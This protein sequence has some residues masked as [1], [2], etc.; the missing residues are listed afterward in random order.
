MRKL[1]F[2]P[3]VSGSKMNIVC[4]VSGSGTNYR[5]IVAGNP[6]RSYLVFTNRPECKGIA[7]AK[8]NGHDTIVL[9]HLPYLKEASRKYG[10]GRV[11]RNCPERVSYEQEISRLIEQ[12]L[13]RQPDLVC[14]AGYDQWFTDWTVER[15][16]PRI[17]NVHPGDTTLGYDGLH[18]IPAAKAILAGDK[19]IRSTLFVVDKGEDSG[20][21]LVQSAPLNIVQTLEGC[22]AKGQKGLLQGL[23]QILTFAS[24]HGLNT[25]EEFGQKAGP[26]VM[27][28]LK[29]ICSLLQDE[30]KVAGD[31]K[32]FPFAV[33]V[34]AAGR[35]EI[36]DRRM[37]L[38]GNKLPAWGHRLDKIR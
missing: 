10:L 32:I 16:Y 13:G 23:N 4:F 7:I 2:D 35:V 9:S 24:T 27:N 14:L 3:A 12:K 1:I 11:P 22:E 20:P 21:V 37:Y 5:E 38:D 6:G 28:A 34:I 8:A 31:W 18:W 30:L 15:Y 25:Y 26:D 17:L 29:E 19:S 36:E 33:N